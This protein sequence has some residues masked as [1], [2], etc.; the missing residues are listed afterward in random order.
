MHFHWGVD[1]QLEAHGRVH[2]TTFHRQPSSSQVTLAR[3]QPG[4]T[5]LPIVSVFAGC[6]DIDAVINLLRAD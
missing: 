4:E 5:R 6:F 3:R 2:T 1:G